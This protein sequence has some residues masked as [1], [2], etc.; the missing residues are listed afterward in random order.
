MFYSSHDEQWCDPSHDEHGPP[1][2]T[3]PV[4]C[5]DIDLLEACREEFHRRLRVYHAW[6]N[7]NK[8]QTG[9]QTA[10]AAAASTS[11]SGAAASAAAASQRAPQEIMQAGKSTNFQS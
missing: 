3:P 2:H 11:P 9:S 6:K 5:L 7:R 10:S 1:L 8:K 4:S